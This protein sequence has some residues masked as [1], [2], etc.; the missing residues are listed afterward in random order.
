[1]SSQ[2][3]EQ[4]Q[5]YQYE[6]L[7]LVDLQYHRTDRFVSDFKHSIGNRQHTFESICDQFTKCDKDDSDFLQFHEE[8]EREMIQFALCDSYESLSKCRNTT[9]CL[10]ADVI[11][12]LKIKL[13][14]TDPR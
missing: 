4:M 11:T 8:F 14:Y 6:M 10:L 5:V 7:D 13:D 2:S 1:M 9:Y 12:K 3:I